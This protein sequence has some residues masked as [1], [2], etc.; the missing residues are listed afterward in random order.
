MR[1]ELGRPQVTA[2]TTAL[3]RTR[4]ALVLL[5]P[6]F[7]LG[8]TAVTQI[9][10][11][12][13]RSVVTSPYTSGD[14]AFLVPAAL[15]LQREG[16]TLRQQLAAV[17]AELDAVQTQGARLSGEAAALQGQIEALKVAAGLTAA[18][19]PGI[20][21]TLDDARLPASFNS[22]A[23][24]QAIVHSQ[25]LTDVFNAAW[26]GG[27]HAIAVNNERITGASAC[28]G[29]TIQINGTLMSPPFVIAIIGPTDRLREVLSDPRQLPDLQA[30][31]RSFGL[32]FTIAPA[33][34]LQVPG[35]SGPV[36]V[37]Y[38]RPL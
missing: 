2:Q 11:Q 12:A 30:R 3:Q 16:N 26:K 17:R 25:D 5:V 10:S 24:A 4:V 36:V 21:V 7:L 37:R 28:V 22:Q 38:A 18:A 6:A 20:I 9:Q 31:Q 15:S 35:F 14:S 32:H 33:D 13:R 34:D 27:A 19:G 8:L 1:D 29:A 23:I